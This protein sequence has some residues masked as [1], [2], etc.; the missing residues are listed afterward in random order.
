MLPWIVLP[1]MSLPHTP[2]LPHLLPARSKTSAMGSIRT[3][4][5]SISIATHSLQHQPA[6]E[7]APRALSEQEA[8]NGSGKQE[9]NVRY[10]VS[11]PPELPY[12][13]YPPQVLH[14]ESSLPTLPGNKTA[15]TGERNMFCE[16]PKHDRAKPRYRSQ[17][18]RT[19]LTKKSRVMIAICEI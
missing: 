1:T 4:P 16:L 10:H 13:F 18:L 7:R 19:A 5:G 9:K 11:P 17:R 3:L 12:Y 2:Y 6:I 14:P 15:Q 8:W